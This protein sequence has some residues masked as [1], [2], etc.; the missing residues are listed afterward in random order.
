MAGALGAG[1]RNGHSADAGWGWTSLE[2]P[3]HAEP[4]RP[5]PSPCCRSGAAVGGALAF[6]HGA[7]IPP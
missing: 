6:V 3:K 7:P 1:V 2:G 4:Q 5:T